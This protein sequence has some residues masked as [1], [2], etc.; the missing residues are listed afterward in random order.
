MAHQLK[1]PGQVQPVLVSCSSTAGSGAPWVQ[2][3]L[4]A[5]TSIFPAAE[6]D[7]SSTSVGYCEEDM[8]TH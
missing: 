7:G 5:Y 1:P 8:S 3:P 2:T 6:G 4:P